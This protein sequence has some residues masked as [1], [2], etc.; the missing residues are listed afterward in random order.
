MRRRGDGHE[1]A[2]PFV[3]AAQYVRE[4]I[5]LRVPPQAVPTLLVLLAHTNS[6]G[7]AWPSAKEISRLTGRKPEN[8]YKDFREIERL[9]IFE[10]IGNVRSPSYNVPGAIVFRLIPFDEERV[11][12]VLLAI[13]IT[14]RAKR[15]DAS[16]FRRAGTAKTRRKEPS[17]PYK[18]APAIPENASSS[19]YN[20]RLALPMIGG[21]ANPDSG[22]QKGYLKGEEKRDLERVFGK[23]VVGRNPFTSSPGGN[24]FPPDP[25][26]DSLSS[27]DKDKGTAREKNQDV[28]RLA[29]YFVKVEPENGNDT[30]GCLKGRATDSEKSK[31]QRTLQR[32]L[33][34]MSR[35]SMSKGR[36]IGDCATGSR[37]PAQSVSCRPY[38]AV[39]TVAVTRGSD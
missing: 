38:L 31:R 30:H 23:G 22:T 32:E 8:I 33:P 15:G 2:T 7:E 14:G 17:S 34:L 5:L 24:A 11:R 19:P 28:G 18:E 37:G 9:H 3:E 35:L 27:Q 10:R 26:S 4:G 21:L 6:K 20:D 25:L 36:R 12:R 1:Q 16:R 29:S 13:P 39:C